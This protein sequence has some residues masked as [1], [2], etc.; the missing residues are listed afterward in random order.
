MI[1]PWFW[2][3]EREREGEVHFSVVPRRL[4]PTITIPEEGVSSGRD[5]L[6]VLSRSHGK[7]WC[8][9]WR[10]DAVFHPVSFATRMTRHST[11]DIGNVTRA[12]LHPNSVIQHYTN[13]TY[14][15]FEFQVNRSEFQFCALKFGGKLEIRLK[16]GFC[17]FWMWR[18]FW[19]T[20]KIWRWKGVG[21]EGLVR[22]KYWNL[23]IRQEE[24]KKI[25]FS[26]F[27]FPRC[28]CFV[29]ILLFLLLYIFLFGDV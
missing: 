22:E 11:W 12:W 13:S 27:S 6:L 29:V 18:W 19:M 25:F 2:E 9:K 24:K 15:R 8:R 28:C 7:H 14:K 4:H 16:N 3:T 21:V 26:L 1:A 5:F 10:L 17:N 23:N 20:V